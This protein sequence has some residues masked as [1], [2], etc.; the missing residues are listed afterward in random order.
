MLAPSQ[1]K[2]QKNQNKSRKT[3][4]KAFWT[5]AVTSQ[6][7]ILLVN[8]YKMKNAWLPPDASDG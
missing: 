2:V 8:A 3:K 5:L 4:E 7:R 1:Q 6:C